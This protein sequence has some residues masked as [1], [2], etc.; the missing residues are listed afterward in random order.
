MILFWTDAQA[1]DLLGKLEHRL[2]WIICKIVGFIFV[3]VVDWHVPAWTD[4][5]WR[6]WVRSKRS[7]MLLLPLLLLQIQTQRLVLAVIKWSISHLP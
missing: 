6:R 7:L 1:I 5:H 3:R 2:P 4:P